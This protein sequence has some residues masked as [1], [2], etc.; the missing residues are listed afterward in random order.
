VQRWLTFIDDHPLVAPHIAAWER[1]VD[2]KT[3]WVA[4][5]QTTGSM[6][7][8][9]DLDWPNDVLQ[10]LGLQ[11]A[12][13]R[14]FASGEIQLPDFAI[15]FFYT[16]GNFDAQV[17]NITAHM[18]R[19]FERELRRTL[20]KIDLTS[21]PQMDAASVLASDRVV[22]LDHNS[23]A[24]RDVIDALEKLEAAI[25]GLN[26]YPT[27]DAKDRHVAELSAGRRC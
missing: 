22:R 26:D 6:V 19:P 24:Y 2:F 20:Q 14:A 15:N 18:F 5:Q 4:A 13:H 9:G 17:Y 11:I 1:S 27:A 23:A 12:L 10:R 8:S 16:D 3:W 21:E 25:A 7:G